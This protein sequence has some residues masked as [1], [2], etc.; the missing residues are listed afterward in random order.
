MVVKG[1]NSDGQN[2]R[3]DQVGKKFKKKKKIPKSIP[4][5]F[6]VSAGIYWNASECPKHTGMAWNFVRGGNK[7][8]NGTEFITLL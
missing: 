1:S 6:W 8:Q 4:A 3:Y 2:V 5:E 7:G